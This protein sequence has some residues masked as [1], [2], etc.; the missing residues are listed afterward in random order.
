MEAVNAV[1]DRCVKCDALLDVSGCNP[2]TETTCP[3]CGGL[4]KVLKEFH[5]YS[6]LSKLGQGGSGTVYRAFDNSLERDVAL[7]LLRNE[8][9]RDPAYVEALEQEAVI[10]AS[11]RHHRI[12]SVFDA[13]QKNGFYY[14][15]MEI[16]SGGTLDQ[17]IQ[18]RSRLSE[19]VSLNIGIQIAEGLQAA[20]KYGLLHR[21][22]KPGNVLFVDDHTVKV[23]DFGLAKRI[24]QDADLDSD[25]WGTP[26]Y[27][28]PEKL[29][30]NGEDIRSDI[31]SFGCTLFHCLTGRP[32]FHS[33]DLAEII[34]KQTETPAPGVQS[35]APEISGSTAYVVKRCLEKDPEARY[36]DY[37]DLIEHLGYAHDQLEKTAA[38]AK[39]KL[40]TARRSSPVGKILLGIAAAASIAFAAAGGI[41]YWKQ[42]DVMT[43]RDAAARDFAAGIELLTKGNYVDAATAMSRARN[44]G[45]VGPSVV[46]WSFLCQGLAGLFGGRMTDARA[47]FVSLQTEVAKRPVPDRELDRFFASIS[48]VVDPSQLGP[49][50][51]GKTFERAGYPSLG[52]LVLGLEQWNLG[53]LDEGA[54]SF[55]K[56]QTATFPDKT[57][58]WIE[59]L[60]P[61][62]NGHLAERSTFQVLA[63]RAKA[64][65]YFEDQTK[66]LKDLEAVQ[67]VYVAKASALREQV[68]AASGIRMPLLNPDMEE[69]EFEPAGWKGTW[70]NPKFSRDT[71]VFH[72]G[73]ASLMV[74]HT[75]LENDSIVGQNFN[76]VEGTLVKV[77]GWIKSAGHG[78]V[79]IL[80]MNFGPQW[81]HLRTNTVKTV[82]GDTDWTYGEAVVT[83]PP[84]TTVFNLGLEVDGDAKG[85]FDDITLSIK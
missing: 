75:G 62:V 57:F 15:A 24:T 49:L 59:K 8:Y 33:T 52:L 47:S 10:T 54:D 83:L 18:L 37:E 74:D 76:A 25:V 67:G 61:A 63:G 44:H 19:E 51:A 1:L 58:A 20:A 70:K 31:Y 40:P 84:E 43:R 12:V 81:K 69:G 55:Q 64:A 11:L 14:I 34:Q 41:Y 71:Q 50:A 23:A 53:Q 48:G 2:L 42:K 7:K 28:A 29:L 4:I 39:P 60:K 9:T 66:L 38:S 73:R 80:V 5:H 79:S 45:D 78:R 56:F 26:A 36:K 16:V 65:T 85:W 13:G 46:Q 27:M 82:Q 35:F 30:R 32:P 6:L 3:N 17:K 68:L 22:V 77:S 72:S 21:D